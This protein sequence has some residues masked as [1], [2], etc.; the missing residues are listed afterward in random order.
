[1]DCRRSARR[2]VRGAPR[3]SRR[4]AAAQRVAA[5]RR[6]VEAPPETRQRLGRR[7]R[8]RTRARCARA[9][10]ARARSAARVA[11][12]DAARDP[13]VP[14]ICLR[15][16][17][18]GRRGDLGL[19]RRGARRP[20]QTSRPLTIS[21]SC[22][23]SPPRA[24]RGWSPGRAAALAG[25]AIVARAAGSPGAATDDVSH[26][27]RRGRRARSRSCRSGLR[28]SRTVARASV[29]RALRLPPPERRAELL[30]PSLAA[31]GVVLLG[32][33]AAQPALT[34][35]SSPRVR[36]DVQALFV[37]DTSR[38]MA[39]SSSPTAPTRLDR[40]AA[41]AVR[42]RA[43]IPQVESGVLT[44]T[45]RVLPDLLPVADVQGFDG[46]VQRAVRIESPPP[47]DTSVRATSYGALGDIAAGN[48]F[49]P[50]A[51]RRIVV[52]LTDG[53]S[54]PVQSG[55]LA[56]KLAAATG[57]PLCGD[58]LLAGRR[59][60]LRRRGQGRGGVPARSLRP[61][62]PA[63]PRRGAWRAELR[64]DPGRARRPR[65]S[66]AS[67]E[68]GRPCARYGSR[69]KSRSARPLRRPGRLL[70]LPR[71]ACFLWRLRLPGIRLRRQ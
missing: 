24:A 30:P 42:L 19:H 44:L 16:A 31:A 3:R 4:R 27:T 11:G 61:D 34:R 51:T 23:G 48:D 67:P 50:T 46:V 28:F 9:G 53:E 18:P 22:C 45:D 56:G 68:A 52:L 70:A 49:A 29:R 17:E 43:A 66:A 54:N 71:C 55:D 5:V 58:P 39:A 20:G 63:R 32:L 60:R 36:R 65:T 59:V 8:S 38:S 13:R 1:M 69:P 40:A 2:R 7:E 15:R 64:G 26:T 41:A 10:L 12:A 14:R 47:R 33:A 21:S 35:T 25:P 57:L 37:L 62:D 6:C